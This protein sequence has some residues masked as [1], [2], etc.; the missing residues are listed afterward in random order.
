MVAKENF[1]TMKIQHMLTIY[2]S[3]KSCL[4][5]NLD[6]YHFFF[7]VETIVHEETWARERELFGERRWETS[8]ANQ[9]SQLNRWMLSFSYVHHGSKYIK[10]IKHV[11]TLHL[12]ESKWYILVNNRSLY[13]TTCLGIKYLNYLISLVLSQPLLV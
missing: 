10:M 13:I 9:F 4:I 7:C 1:L 2:M 12:H 8:P 11:Y 3:S 5:Q 6:L